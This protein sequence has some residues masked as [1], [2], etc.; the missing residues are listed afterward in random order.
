MKNVLRLFIV[1]I[2]GGSYIVSKT[3]SLQLILEQKVKNI[4][5][6]SDMCHDI[7]SVP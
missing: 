6:H 5:Q 2:S 1:I 4:I 3:K 7:S